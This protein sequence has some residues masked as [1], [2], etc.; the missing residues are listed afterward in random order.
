[1]KL[2]IHHR[3]SSFSK[4]WIEYCESNNIEW[5]EVDCYKSDIINQLSDCDALMWH[6]FHIS[7]KDPVFAKQLLFALET[8]G[9]IVYPDF[10]S[11]WHFNDKLGQKYLLESIKAP[12]VPSYAFYSKSDAIDWIRKTSFPKVFKLRGGSGSDSVRLVKTRRQ[13]NRIISKAFGRGFRQYHPLSNLKERYRQYRMGKVGFIEVLKGLSRLFFPPQYA[14]IL[15]RDRGYV[16]FHDFIP[17]NTHDI[18]VTYVYN[19]CFALRRKVRA[20]DFRA[21]GSGLIEYDMSMI[22]GEALSI[23]FRVANKLKLQCAAFDF[24]MLEDKPLIV[25]VSYGFGYDADQFNH[26]YWDENLNYTP[27]TFDPYGWM[28]EGVIK[29]VQDK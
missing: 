8:S 9:K 2:A 14:R 7:P 26:G 18:R 4:Y 27:G 6:H 13:A 11:N 3:K 25:E 12:A 23:A 20:G 5:K 16:Y 1:M 21:S 10:R 22:P 28:V 29:E 15:K 17:E 19:R 24:V